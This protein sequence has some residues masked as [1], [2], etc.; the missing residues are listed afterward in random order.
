VSYAALLAFLL[1]ALGGCYSIKQYT[2]IADYHRSAVDIDQ[3]LE[4]DSISRRKREFLLLVKDIKAYA[5][6]VLGLKQD[7]NY[8][9]YVETD[10]P[11]LLDVVSACRPDAFEPYTWAVP[12]IGMLPYRGYFERGEALEECKAL[13]NKGF[14]VVVRRVDA[15]SSLG[16]FSEPVFSYMDRYGVFEI[17]S[18][19]IHEQTHATL[20]FRDQI[21]L[22][23][24]LA[25]FVG[26]QGALR[27]IRERWGSASPEYRAARAFLRDF[28]VFRELIMEL[29]CALDE[30]Y[31]SGLRRWHKLKRKRELI[32]AWKKDFASRYNDRFETDAFAGFKDVPLNN[33][34][35]LAYCLYTQDLDLFEGLFEQSGRSLKEMMRSLEELSRTQPDLRGFLSAQLTACD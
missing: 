3:V 21:E 27:Y 22:S 31:E 7:D 5:T 25:T 15:Y 34:H 16:L 29:H 12:P 18:L 19:L 14:D 23:E 20:F 33:A 30:V 35:I 4:E 1:L 26:Y 24:G 32:R 13:E 11:Y 8:T 10:R 17:A 2:Y 6:R 28:D 9:R